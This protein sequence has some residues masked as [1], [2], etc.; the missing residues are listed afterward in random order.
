MTRFSFVHGLPRSYDPPGASV[1]MYCLTDRAAEPGVLVETE[2]MLA[3]AAY[4]HDYAAH[5]GRPQI[6]RVSAI[7]HALTT[8]ARLRVGGVPLATLWMVQT[9]G[10]DAIDALVRALA[11]APLPGAP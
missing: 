9:G 10:V 11:P 7:V 5:I 6:G 4:A 1:P 2:T 3:V 8:F